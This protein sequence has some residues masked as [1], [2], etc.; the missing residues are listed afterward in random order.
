[1]STQVIAQNERRLDLYDTPNVSCCCWAAHS[2][3]ED[4]A[5]AVRDVLANNIKLMLPEA[6]YSL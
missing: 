3:Q 1:M 2:N 5:L 6:S 4:S